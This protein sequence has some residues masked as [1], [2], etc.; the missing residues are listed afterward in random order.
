MEWKLG[1]EA[2]NDP[3][4]QTTTVKGDKTFLNGL[5][6]HDATLAFGDSTQTGE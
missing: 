1:L 4:S 2:R 6:L 5:E 3:E